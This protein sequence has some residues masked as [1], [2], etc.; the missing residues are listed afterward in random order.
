MV[1]SLQK[2]A[3]VSLVMLLAACSND[4]SYKHQVNGNEDYLK[5]PELRELRAPAGMV[6]PMQNGQYGINNRVSDAG[7]VG[8]ALDIRPPSQ[9]LALMAG[10]RVQFSGN[11]AT[12]LL[13]DNAKNQGLWNQVISVLESK[14]YR[15]TG[16]QEASQTLTT[17]WVEWPR[18]DEKVA[19]QARYQI[20]VQQQAYQHQLS[21]KVLELKADGKTVSDAANMQRYSISMLNTISEGLEKRQNASNAQNAAGVG[22]MVVQAAADDTGLPVAIVRAPYSV[23]WERLPAALEKMGMTITD[24]NRPQGTI[25]VTFK[26]SNSNWAALSVSNPDLSNG[27]YKIQVGDLDNRTSL[28]F[29]T[30]KGRVLKEADNAALVTILQAALNQS[31]AV[32]K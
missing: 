25:A 11:T 22:S 30:D 31:V 13:E 27:D 1:H 14:G 26:S 12:L 20:G 23:V 3:G 32:T 29:S 9:P 17:D 21:V 2:A 28:Q 8:Y 18:G 19:Y 4:Q 6:L 15:I 10:S 5:A 7:S 24:S 16:H